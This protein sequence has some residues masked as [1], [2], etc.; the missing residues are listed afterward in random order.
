M[1]K[2]IIFVLL[3]LM[4][5]FLMIG[6]RN[7][8]PNVTIDVANAKNFRCEIDMSKE[9]KPFVLGE[10]DAAYLFKNCFEYKEKANRIKGSEVAV[11]TD[12]INI[13]ILCNNII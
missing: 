1:K 9:E 7:T 13:H 10:K 11:T 2:V 8:E 3:I 4:L 5:S 12:F 6:C